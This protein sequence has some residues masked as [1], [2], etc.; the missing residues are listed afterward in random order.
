MNQV[1]IVFKGRRRSFSSFE[2][3]IESVRLNILLG[4]FASAVERELVEFARAV[5][6]V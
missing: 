3:A 1:H 4:L 6:F 2:Q 5:F